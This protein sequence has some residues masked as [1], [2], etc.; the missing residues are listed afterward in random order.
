MPVTRVS[1][2]LHGAEFAGSAATGRA[3]AP[4]A[5]RLADAPVTNAA[6]VQLFR[7]LFRGREDLFSRRWENEKKGRA[8]YS[9]ACDNEWVWGSCEKKKGSAAGKRSTCGR[10][11]NRAFI[12]VSDEEI[13]KHLRG[14]Q[15]MGVYPLLADE[16]CWFLAGDFDNESWEEDVSALAGTCRQHGLPVSIER[17]R[18]GNG[19]H[20]WFFFGS[21]VSAIA[22][23]KLGRFLITETMARHHQLS[24]ESYDR[25]FPNQD[26]MP[27][28]GFGNLIALPLQRTARDAGN[29]VFVDDSFNPWPDQ[30]AFLA[31]VQRID[32]SFVYA[33]C[34]RIEG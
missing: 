12:P 14:D 1:E 8:G 21:P 16:T 6:K 28:G 31:S 11:H 13:A 29:T 30:W 2:H 26:T 22:A 18:S 32:A 17:S 34:K 23:R 3:G 19:A 25:L 5:L 4:I 33:I 27:R 10:C 20:A 24:M 15:V 9:P 7:S